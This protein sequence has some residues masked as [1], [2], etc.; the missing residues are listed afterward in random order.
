[1]SLNNIFLIYYIILII[2]MHWSKHLIFS[3]ALLVDRTPDVCNVYVSTW[4]YTLSACVRAHTLPPL[5]TV[6]RAHN[7]TPKEYVGREYKNF[8]PCAARA[9]DHFFCIKPTP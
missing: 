1:M 9:Q 2:H 3:V 6:R 5:G 8:D 7:Y 4:M